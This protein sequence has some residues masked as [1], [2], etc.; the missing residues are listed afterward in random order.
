ML[1]NSLHLD[2]SKIQSSTRRHQPPV[3]PRGAEG[4]EEHAHGPQDRQ[5]QAQVSAGPA[6]HFAS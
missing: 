5:H 2:Q 4:E 3:L 6:D 1:K